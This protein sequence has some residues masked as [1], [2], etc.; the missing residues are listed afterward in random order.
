MVLFYVTILAQYQYHDHHLV[1]GSGLAPRLLGGGLRPPHNERFTFTNLNKL[2]KRK[3]N[4]V[5]VNRGLKFTFVKINVLNPHH[6][7]TNSEPTP[8]FVRTK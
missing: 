1:P 3:L 5:N 6:P 7:P 2:T 8:R 4:F